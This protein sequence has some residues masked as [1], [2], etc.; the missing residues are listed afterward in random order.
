M[1]MHPAQKDHLEIQK[2][3][4]HVLI[5][6]GGIGGLCL[7]QGLKKSGISVAVYERDQSVSFRNQGYRISLK[8]EGSRALR[9]CLPENLFQL[10]VATAIKSATRMV[11]LDH[12]LNQKFAKPIPPLPEDAFFGVHRLTLREILLAGLEEMVHFGKTFVQ[13]DHVHDGRI[14]ASFADGTQAYGDLLVGA[15][16][17]HSAVRDLLV[18]DAVIDDLDCAIYGKT[19]LTPELLERVPEVLLDSFNRM[20]D[21][22]G[23]SLSVA[24]CRKREAW[25]SATK[26]FAPNLH[27]TEMPDYLSWTLSRTHESLGGADGLSLHR[28]ACSLLKGWLSEVAR[29]VEEAESAATFLVTIRSAQPVKPWH[30]E[31]VTLLGDAI[32]TMSPGRGEGANTALRDAQLLRSALADVETGGVPLT[33]AKI[34]YETTMLPYGF[35]AVANSRE[36][37]FR[38]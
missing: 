15:D 17:T 10:T 30:T 1:M 19:L 29:I 25:T 2:A 24:T 12:R 27:L 36:H 7:A 14:L 8:E 16:G 35:E 23:V 6:G 28:L 3:P 37:P 26:R 4:L 9:D 22:D 33:Q 32:H 13:F 11:F 31:Q 18:P 20:S 21:P 34:Q 5:I 38:K